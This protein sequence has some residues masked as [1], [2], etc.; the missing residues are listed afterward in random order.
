M[1]N[2]KMTKKGGEKK[3]KK[4]GNK[5]EVWKGLA[6]QTSSGITKDGL[7]YNAKGDIVY[8]KA[9]NA[10]KKK[11]NLGGFIQNARKTPGVFK[12]QPKKGTS[13][14]YELLNKSKNLI[15]TSTEGST[16][17]STESLTQSS[18]ESSTETLESSSELT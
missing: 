2:K 18:T 4:Y 14:Y 17:S 5:L 12:K 8:K 1:F 7:K 15:E 11:S 9:S 13:E 10:A 6:L 16:Q 3:P